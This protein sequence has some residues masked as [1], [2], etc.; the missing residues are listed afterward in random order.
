[1]CTTR[2]ESVIE[3]YMTHVVNHG[4]KQRPF[5]KY[6]MG[7][8]PDLNQSLFKTKLYKVFDLNCAVSRHVSLHL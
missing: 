3:I 5:I 1:M 6:Q 7:N 2:K 8:G 4:C